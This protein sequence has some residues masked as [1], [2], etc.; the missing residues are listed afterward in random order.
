MD[1]NGSARLY[2]LL[3]IEQYTYVMNIR[4][5]LG[6]FWAGERPDVIPFTIYQNEW[7]HTQNDPAWRG[8]YDKGLGVTWHF[9]TAWDAWPND[10]E[11]RDQT[12]AKDGKTTLKRTISTPVGAVHEL[13]EDA[14]RQKHFLETAQDYAVMTY[15]VENLEIVPFYDKYLALEESI[16]PF[17]VAMA[18]AGRTPNQSILVDFVGLKN[19]AFHLVDL[20]AEMMELYEALLDN[21]RKKVELVADGPGRFVS[22]LENFTAETLGPRR[23]EKL[24]LPVY[25][26]CF[27]IL[28]QAGKVVGTHYDGQLA[29]CKE[30]IADAPIDLIESLTPPPEGDLTLE[31]ARAVWPDKLFWSNINVACYDLPPEELKTEVLKR[32][33]EAAVDGC[34][35]AFE[36]SEQYPDNWKESLPIVLEALEETRT[37]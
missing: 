11:Q 30:L 6:V 14:W 28:R 34:R 27:P 21:F 32:V 22:V 8:L 33:E 9:P 25:E 2:I 35:L 17:G 12:V 1:F 5:R 24:L 36:V 4:E 31:Q 37:F 10:V 29:S 20:E 3:P 15:L 19:Y 26:E 23:F 13:Y 7:R 16:A 18:F